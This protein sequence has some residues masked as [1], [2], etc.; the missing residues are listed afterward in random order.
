M[1][2]PV[3]LVDL[4]FLREA[5]FEIVLLSVAGGVVGAWVLLRRLAFYSHAVGSATFPGL[6]TADATGISPTL[7]ALAVALGYAGGV[8]AVRAEGERSEAWTALLLVAALATGVILAS[9]VFESGASVDRLLFGTLLGLDASDLWLSG[10]CAVAALAA[11][12]AFGRVWAAAGFD[13]DAAGALGLRTRWADLGL[14]ALVA[15]AAVAAIPAVG[16]LLVSAV[17]ILPAASARLLARSVRGLIGWAVVLALAEGAT[18]LYL[19]YWLDAPPGP[20]I[21]V[22]GAATYATLA[23][24]AAVSGLRAAAVPA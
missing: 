21:A 18:G 24:T 12:L 1:P 19:A 17:F 13:P 9:D 8:G 2:S 6:V 14:L 4:P 16:A 10:A 20:P 7:L 11:T 5:L 22:L 3:D 23:V 15:L